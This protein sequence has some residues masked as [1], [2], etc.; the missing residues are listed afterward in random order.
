ML[1][2][3]HFLS[4]AT[5][6]AGTGE[7]MVCG[8]HRQLSPIIAHDWEREDRPPVTIYQPYAS[9]YDA[10]LRLR[11]DGGVTDE[12]IRRSALTY[13]F[14]LPPII[15]ELISR[16]YKRDDIDLS[17]ASAGTRAIGNVNQS[18]WE[19]LWAGET[20]LYLV[21]HG[22][23][24]SRKSNP[25]EVE[26]LT[27]I[28]AAGGSQPAGSIGIITPH[29]A[30]RA[31]ITAA[32]VGNPA[33]D[34]VDTVERLQGGERQTIIVSATAS[35]NTAISKSAEFILDLNRSNVAFSRAQRR[36]IVICSE[37][38]L[39]HIPAEL[40]DYESTLLWKSLREVCSLAIGDD[41]VSGHEVRIYTPPISVPNAAEE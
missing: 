32:V 34:V 30:Q 33:V 26:I 39:D 40:E 19:K 4:L 41:V 6:L 29:R 25:T 1:I 15:R 23:R 9:A 5:L 10:V 2:F 20:G 35:D 17:G 22:E 8:D 31:M 24:E 3:P 18:V 27:R 13:S 16:L 21:I 11:E 36:L 38:L 28:L 12:S 14:R 37:T 7:V